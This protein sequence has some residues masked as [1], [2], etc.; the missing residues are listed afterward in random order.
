MT[1]Y[2]WDDNFPQIDVQIQ[3]NPS[4]NPSG[5]F[6]RNWWA[7]SNIYVEKQMI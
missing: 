5:H 3:H 7:D 1:Q 2:F 6:G 4:Q